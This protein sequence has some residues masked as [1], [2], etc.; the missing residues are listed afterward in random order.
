[1]ANRRLDYLDAQELAAS[2]L[3][4]TESDDTDNTDAVE[5]AL[6]KKFE[7]SAETFQEIAEELFNRID[8][9]ISPLTNEA[10]IGFV[11]K[12][13]NMF[14]VKEDISSQFIGLVVQWSTE[15]EK[16]EPGKGFQKEITDMDGNVEFIITIK[17][18]KAE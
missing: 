3:N 7:I 14:F 16:L 9:G 8:V 6:A 5:D 10:Y 4:I 11:N 13:R 2:I 18:P 12:E 15:G 17:K 1:M